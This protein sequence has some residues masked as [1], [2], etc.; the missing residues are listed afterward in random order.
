[1]RKLVK[2]LL[3]MLTVLLV[4]TAFSPLAEAHRHFRGG[5]IIGPVYD[6]WYDPWYGPGY[7]YY[8]YGYPPRYNYRSDYGYLWTQIEPNK[9]EVW[10]DGDY[11]GLVKEFDGPVRHLLLPIGRHKVEFRLKGYRT[12]KTSVHISP[13]GTTSVEYDLVPLAK[14]ETGTEEEYKAE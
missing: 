7:P 8:P 13:D 11:F 6:P 9:A 1:M 5:V 4:L 3:G 14:G 10:V 2:A 12:F